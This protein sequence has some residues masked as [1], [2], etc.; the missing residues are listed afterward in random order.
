LPPQDGHDRYPLSRYPR[1]RPLRRT[2]KVGLTP[3]KGI[4]ILGSTGSI[5]NQTLDI[6]RLFPERLNVCALTAGGNSDLL[7]QQAREFLPE[8]VVI[9][10]DDK[11]KGVRDKLS[12]LPVEV[13]SGSEG[14]IAAA[15]WPTADTVVT[16]V[17]GAAGLK[18]TVAAAEKGK[19]I[20]LA[21]K[22]TLVIAGQLLRSLAVN[23]GA[24]IIPI[25]S[26]HS[27]IFQCLAGESTSSIESLHLTASGGPFRTLPIDEFDSITKEMALRHPNWDMGPKITIDS[28]TMMNKGLEIIEAHWLFGIEAKDI[29]V[30]VHP[31]SIVHSMVTFVDGSVKAQLGIPDMKVPI[32]YA[33]SYP[34]RWEA[35]HARLDWTNQH[36]LHFE[37]PDTTRFPALTLAYEA[38]RKGGAAPAVLNA[39]NEE[40]VCLFL[41]ERIRF[42]DI[43]KL[44]D[45]ALAE[46]GDL[47]GVTMS[48]LMQAD[49]EARLRVQELSRVRVH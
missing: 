29:H 10:D 25:D 26:E 22:E 47:E 38:L 14:M 12:G 46:L 35:P 8:C 44:L 16:A 40:A 45:S 19:R 7:L 20:A 48:D 5:G 37:E 49:R 43:P 34:E 6:V 21:N 36:A 41:G 18:P 28:A 15:E 27:A 33:L 23:R 24:D 39:A 13:L 17:V 30:V 1:P 11:W 9:G 2:R 32:Q 3:K 4:S 31:Q 42:A